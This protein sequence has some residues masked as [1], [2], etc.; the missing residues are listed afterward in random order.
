MA[1]N[2]TRR[3]LRARVGMALALALLGALGAGTA[4][5]EPALALVEGTV[6]I[7][8]GDPP[9]WRP[10]RAGELLEPGQSI[11][12]GAGGHAEV[13][14]ERGTVRLYENSLL[15]L[16]AEAFEG[17]SSRAV[18]LEE[19]SGLFDVEPRR[20]GD[21]FEVRTPEAVVMVKGTRFAVDLSEGQA[22]VSVFHGLVGVRGAADTLEHEV[23][24]R[25]GLTA[26]GG[27]AGGFELRLDR[28]GDPWGRWK[29]EQRRAPE[30]G[31]S[32]AEA[33]R[34][35]RESVR[36]EIAAQLIKENPELRAALESKLA[37]G[38]PGQGTAL[39]AH[40]DP[41]ADSPVEDVV[42][43]VSEGFAEQQ[44]NPSGPAPQ[45][46]DVE[47]VDSSGSGPARVIFYQSDG[48]PI[49]ALSK[50]ELQN[51]AQNGQT[52]LYPA[53]ILQNLI[54]NQTDPVGYAGTL[55]QLLQNQ[56]D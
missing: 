19:G 3:R 4:R 56:D 43:R 16:P 44:L 53:P 14:L 37:G 30:G 7:G 32:E 35:V 22:F 10:A 54:S 18:E 31:A 1:T 29:Q 5:A 12:V 2:Q 36:R 49:G 51:I 21:G 24:V 48:T 38:E 28:G 34:A 9:L 47:F 27:R 41:V 33:A 15:R 13:A 23:L 52:A 55:H 25:P 20:P 6:E 11:R 46:F 17:E 39:P 45:L 26:I 8:S 42:D 50:S 40:P